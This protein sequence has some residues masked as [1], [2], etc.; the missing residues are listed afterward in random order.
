[1]KIPLSVLMAEDNEED[2]LLVLHELRKNGYD[3]THECVET[4]ED[5]RNALARGTWDM[6][7]SDYSFP[8]FSGREALEIFRES[9]LDVPF[10]FVSG[11]MGEEAAVAAMK[12]GAHDY[13]MKGNLARLGPAVERELGEAEKR[14]AG[15]RAE[16][17]MRESEHKY[18][19]LFEALGDAAF[20][21]DEES[22]RIIDANIRVETLLGWP[23]T[24]ILGSNQTRLFARED[25]SANGKALC[26]AAT[27][28]SVG[29]EMEVLH[30]DGHRVPVHVS[31]S[32][33]ELYGRHLLLLLLRDV[34]D[35]NRMEER[36]RQLSRAVEQSPVSVT[37]TDPEGNIVYVNP[38]FTAL[39]G[40]SP[41]EV[42]G[43]NPRI[44]K[45]GD[46]P[47]EAY[48]R[49]WKTITSGKEW[50]GKF[51]N[52]KKNGDLFWE[53]ALITPI[54]NEAGKITHFLAVEMDLPGQDVR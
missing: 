14:R 16:T 33:L 2:A 47:P 15:R 25:A 49:L 9:G 44:L 37:I 29:C 39:T 38:R 21:I 45:S 48:A 30:R 28:C 20:V 8:K 11:T 26:A 18:R 32:R 27:E 42:L 22:G 6:I 53:T 17:A 40:Y 34:S 41:D 1:M 13:L 52:R 43:K 24:E 19:Q 36:L 46:T 12:A 35:R 5:F 3:V 31:V 23:H 51:H 54:T 4:P 50:R 7:L 10:L